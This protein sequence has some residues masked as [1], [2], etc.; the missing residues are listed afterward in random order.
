M[1]STDYLLLPA[2]VLSEYPNQASLVAAIEVDHT[3]KTRQEIAAYTK[4][5]RAKLLDLFIEYDR[6]YHSSH[7]L[8]SFSLFCCWR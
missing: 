2:E 6:Y 8:C 5:A 7:R 4:A 1:L 3:G